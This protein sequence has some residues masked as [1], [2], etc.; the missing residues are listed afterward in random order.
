[1]RQV[2]QPEFEQFLSSFSGE[3]GQPVET[4]RHDG[5]GGVGTMTVFSNEDVGLLGE[6]HHGAGIRT[7]AGP[8]DVY[9]LTL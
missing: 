2:T 4:H 9:L 7:A 6:I 5:L 1:M 8:A 3:S